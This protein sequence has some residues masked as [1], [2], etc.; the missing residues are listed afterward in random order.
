M[1]YPNVCE[2]TIESPEWYF[3]LFVEFKI[4]VVMAA[5]VEVND[6][7]QLEL[8]Q[9]SAYKKR[10]MQN[11]WKD[12]TMWPLLRKTDEKRNAILKL[13][14]YELRASA[15]RLFLSMIIWF[16]DLTPKW[17]LYLIYI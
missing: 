5:L 11:W 12:R 4:Q 9:M 3:N 16:S 1:H 6:S 10:L 17:T 13:W 14:F 2:C 8:N 15:Y 7:E